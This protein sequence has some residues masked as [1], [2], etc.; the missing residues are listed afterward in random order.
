MRIQ[1]LMCRLGIRR[2]AESKR[3]KLLR[4]LL[5]VLSTTLIMIWIVSMMARISIHGANASAWAHRGCI[6]FAYGDAISSSFECSYNPRVLGV[7]Y[8]LV[9]PILPY[10][11]A[12]TQLWLA[13]MPVW[14]ALLVTG[15]A[16]LVL[17][18]FKA[19]TPDT[20]HCVCGYNLFANLSGRCPEC[21][22]P[23]TTATG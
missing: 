7:G 8:G 16:T 23:A 11:D 4:R 10:K 20:H 3:R 1:S 2:T 22:R 17:C 5:A 21:G 6:S 14:L 9:R 18:I 12:T 15:L 13:K 19:E